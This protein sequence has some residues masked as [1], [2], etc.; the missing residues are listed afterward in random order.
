MSDGFKTAYFIINVQSWYIKDQPIQFILTGIIQLILDA[1][2]I[3]Q[4][5]IYR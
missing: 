2:L 1:F 4:I 3:L 5:I